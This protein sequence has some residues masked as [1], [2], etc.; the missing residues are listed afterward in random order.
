M[1][2]KN[3]IIDQSKIEWSEI[4]RD[5]LWLIPNRLTVWIMNRFGDLFVVLEDGTVHMLDVGGGTLSK[6]AESREEFSRI[7][8]ECDNAKQWLMIPLV[9]VGLLVYFMFTMAGRYVSR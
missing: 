8:D 2:I 1:D 7:I 6:I 5:W 4:L 3:Y 9:L